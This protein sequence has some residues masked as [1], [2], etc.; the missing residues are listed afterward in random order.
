MKHSSEQQDDSLDCVYI[1]EMTDLENP[2][3]LSG[4]F[5]FVKNPGS[6]IKHEPGFLRDRKEAFG[7]YDLRELT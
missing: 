7:A 1:Y 5:R 3:F 2:D 6:Y 4:F